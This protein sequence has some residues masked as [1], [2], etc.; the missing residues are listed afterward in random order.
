LLPSG[1]TK[2]LGLG[3]FDHAEDID[4]EHGMMR[5]DG[6][7][8]FADQG[9]VRHFFLVADV[10]HVVDDVARVFA[11][12][13][14]RAAVVG[15]AAAVV[16]DAEAAAHVEVFEGKAELLELGVIA[17]RLPAPRA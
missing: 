14:I 15:G 13:V 3:L 4:D 10:G 17:G 6:A 12:R 7:A 1:A 9:R 8:A 11:E 16:I 2:R 5:D